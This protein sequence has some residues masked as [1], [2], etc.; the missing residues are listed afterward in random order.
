MTRS[1]L[2]RRHIGHISAGWLMAAL[3]DSEPLGAHRR[4]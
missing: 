2:S 4:L 3:V 1:S